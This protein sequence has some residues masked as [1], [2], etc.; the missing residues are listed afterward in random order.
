MQVVSLYP[1][2][3]LVVQV[4]SRIR[5]RGRGASM[6][7]GRRAAIAASSR[8]WSAWV[9][10]FDGRVNARDRRSSAFDGL[11]IAVAK[12]IATIVV[13]TLF[14]CCGAPPPGR[15]GH[16]PGGAAVML[17]CCSNR[18]NIHFWHSCK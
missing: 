17:R 5:I 9:Q 6:I 12:R 18:E 2:P 8:A 7:I 3:E 4:V 11:A 13:F 15:G 16:V 10:S 1:R 14:S